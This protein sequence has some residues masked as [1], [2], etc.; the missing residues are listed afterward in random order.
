MTRKRTDQP[1]SGQPVPPEAVAKPLYDFAH[2]RRCPGCK[3]TDTVAVSTQGSV[4]YRSCRYALCEYSHK[5]Y[6]VVGKRI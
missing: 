5:N 6:P 3:G 1:S 4:Q 2:G